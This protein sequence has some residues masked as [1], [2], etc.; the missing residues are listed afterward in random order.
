MRAIG[1]D[2]PNGWSWTR[3]RPRSIVILES[4]GLPTDQ[5][6]LKSVST[7]EAAREVHVQMPDMGFNHAL[8][9]ESSGLLHKEH[10]PVDALERF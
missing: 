3:T 10:S 1:V 7:L 4:L 8:C 5:N 6:A 2:Q 9:T